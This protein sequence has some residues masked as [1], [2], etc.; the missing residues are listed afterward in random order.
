[1]RSVVR[2]KL[3]ATAKLV[4]DPPNSPSA[5]WLSFVL[6]DGKT[7]PTDTSRAF[8]IDENKQ[9]QV[10]IVAPPDAIRGGYSFKLVVAE[11][12]NPD[13]NFSESP[14]VTFTVPDPVE[15]KL[16]IALIIGIIVVV[17][18]IIIAIVA[19]VAISGNNQTNSNATGTAVAVTQTATA[20]V[21]ATETVVANQTGTA[22]AIIIMTQSAVPTSTRTS[23]PTQ[24]STPT[25]TPTNTPTPTP[26]PNSL[27]TQF[28]LIDG[29]VDYYIQLAQ[30]GTIRVVPSWTGFNVALAITIL[31]SNQRTA[32]SST[33]NVSG[34]AVEYTVST[35][36]WQ[37]SKI[38]HVNIVNDTLNSA[39][40]A[41]DISY[42]SGVA[43]SQPFRDQFTLTQS[44]AV[45][46][47]IVALAH[48]GTI[49]GQVSWSGASNAIEARIRLPL[50]GDTF[51]ANS[52]TASPMAVTYNVPDLAVGQLWVVSLIRQ[53][54]GTI[55][56]TVTV[57]FP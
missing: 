11:D 13:D 30:P 42:P 12:T 33:T 36:D 35:A 56:G 43:G 24:T 28:Q 4:T 8:D 27:G 16:P 20:N 22:N 19:V 2:R 3:D 48:T 39:T 41:V 38:W 17:L 14:T 55:S 52:H 47:V 46:N 49:S 40:G 57:H 1:V 9:Y 29:S 37:A 5:K 51:L 23:T 53:T 34:S 10:K 25:S 44:S 18:V 31:D 26:I 6:P 45:T 54:T 15:R 50:Q 21:A 7:S 32:Q